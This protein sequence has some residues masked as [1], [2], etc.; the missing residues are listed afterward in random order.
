MICA[1]NITKEDIVE[2]LLIIVNKALYNNK[3][4][5]SL[6]KDEFK[7]KALTN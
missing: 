3:K 5:K 7:L 2:E 4:E 6:Q 1:E